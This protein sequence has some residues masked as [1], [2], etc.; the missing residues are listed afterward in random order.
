LF[1]PFYFISIL[2]RRKRPIRWAVRNGRRSVKGK[3]MMKR[4]NI[5][6]SPL[7]STDH[8]CKLFGS[9]L[10]IS[11]TPW[12]DR[13][14]RYRSTATMFYGLSVQGA[15]SAQFKPAMSTQSTL[16]SP[17]I[18]P[19]LFTPGLSPKLRYLDLLWICCTTNLQQ[20]HSK[21][22]VYRKSTTSC[23]TNRTNPSSAHIPLVD[24]LD[25]LPTIQ[26]WLSTR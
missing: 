25:K 3:A 10:Q 23:T 15:V 12:R 22:T 1:R 18:A 26:Q 7:R 13:A 24:L 21:S 17:S 19:S 20:V 2:F 11:L 6:Q 4:F 16:L 8:V 9:D 5:F 14:V